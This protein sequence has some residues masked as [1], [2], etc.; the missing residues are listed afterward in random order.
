[1]A[2]ANLGYFPKSYKALPDPVPTHE[3]QP[4]LYTHQ[5]YQI[6]QP[7]LR[8]MATLLSLEEECWSEGMRAS[9]DVIRQRI[10]ENTAGQCLL[11]MDGRAIGVIY[12]QRVN[13]EDKIKAANDGNVHLLHER[14]GVLAQ[15]LAVNVFPNMQHLGLGDQLLAFMVNYSFRRQGIEKVVAVTRCKNYVMHRDMTME[16]YIRARNKQGLL[17][18][19]ILRFHDEHGASIDALIPNYRAGDG[20]NDG[21]GV[22]ISYDPAKGTTE[23]KEVAKAD[24]LPSHKEVIK[25]L[26]TSVKDL[27]EGQPRGGFQSGRALLDMGLDSLDL[28][29]LRLQLVNQL[30]VD[31]D[32]T[33]FFK[34]ATPEA[35]A[36]YISTPKREVNFKAQSPQTKTQISAEPAKPGDI[37]RIRQQHLRAISGEAV[38]V[39]GMACRLGGKTNNVDDFWN[40][41]EQGVD[42]IVEVPRNRYDI[43]RYYNPEPGHPGSLISK[44]GS[45]IENVD[46][47]D[48]EFF[49]INPREA[50]HLDPSQ[51]TLMEVAW[52]ALEDACLDPE[53]LKGT[54]AGI[55]TGVFSTDYE[56]LQLREQ[57]NHVWDAYFATGNCSSMTAGRL[58]YFLGFQ[59]PAI[60]VNTAC[61]S[62]LVAVHLACRS[63]MSGE[64][65][66]AL[67]GGV[68][69][70]LSP[71][72]SIAFSRAGMLSPDGR[73]KTFD[74]TANGYVRGEGC[75]IVVLKSLNKAIAAN[76]RIQGILRGGAINQDGASNGLTAPNGQAQE[77]VIRE[78]L[79]TAGV[80]PIDINYVEA[81]GTGTPLGDPIEVNALRDIY[82]PGRDWDNPLYVGSVKTNIGHTEAAA[83]VVGLIK[84]VLSMKNRKI[85]QHLHFKEPNP[86]LSLEQ[87]PA[88]IPTETVDWP[89]LEKKPRLGS[90][91]SFGFSG[92]NAHMVVQ[93]GLPPKPAKYSTL[94]HQMLALS[95][96]SPKALTELTKNFATFLEQDVDLTSACLSA[97]VGRSHFFHRLAVT[98]DSREEMR[99]RLLEEAE[100]E[101]PQDPDKT[102]ALAFL[103]TGQGSQY[104]NMGRELYENLPTFRRAIDQCDEILRDVADIHLIESLYP[105]FEDPHALNQTEIT[106]PAIFS[107][108]YA[109]YQVW[110][111]WGIE[112]Q[113][114]LGHS[115]GEYVAAHVAGIYSL[116]DGLRLIAE[117][118]RLMQRLPFGGAMAAVMVDEGTLLEVLAGFDDISIAAFNGPRS[119]VISGRED[120]IDH[121]LQGF[122]ERG[123]KCKKLSVSHAFHSALMNPMLDQ[124]EAEAARL[125]LKPPNIDFI[126]SVT[127]AEASAA[128][129]TPNY[130]R[131]Q[132]RQAVLFRP[133]VLT[134]GR[135][136][137]NTFLEIGPT[138]TL[139]ALGRQ[140]MPDEATFLSSLR[141]GRS[142]WT[143]MLDTLS[144]LYQR[145]ASV[146]FSGLHK[147]D[148]VPKI[149][150]PGYP[151]QRRSFWFERTRI[152]P[153]REVKKE[154]R[155]THPLLGRRL[156]MAVRQREVVFDSRL[157][158]KSAAYLEDYRVGDNVLLPATASLEMAR[159]AGAVVFE[160]LP[161]IVEDVVFQKDLP[162][163]EHDEV[164]VQFI[165][166]P[167]TAT[168]S[169]F[170]IYSLQDDQH[171]LH[172]DFEIHVKG[173]LAA[174][175]G[176]PPPDRVDVDALRAS[177][178]EEM[179]GTLLYPKLQRVGLEYGT[180]MQTIK[181]IWYSSNHALGR[182]TI[183]DHLHWDEEHYA[184]HP[185]LLKGAFQLVKLLATT[186]DDTAM[187]PRSLKR[188]TIFDHGHGSL[189]CHAHVHDNMADID[190]FTDDG[191]VI[192]KIEGLGLEEVRVLPQPEAPWHKWLMQHC[193]ES[194]SLQVTLPQNKENQWLIFATGNRTAQALIDQMTRR[195]QQCILVE[196]GEDF[197]RLSDRHFALPSRDEHAYGQLLQSLTEDGEAIDGVVY[198]GSEYEKHQAASD[199]T[200]GLLLLVRA[201]ME[202]G[203]AK[204]PHLHVVTR[205]A[206]LVQDGETLPGHF[207]S[208]LRGFTHVVSLEH[209]ELL[210]QA[211]DLDPNLDLHELE[212]ISEA[213]IASLGE[214]EEYQK[215]ERFVAWR[216]GKAFVK[217]L[218]PYTMPEVETYS[219][220]PNASYM[221]TGGLG[222]LGLSLAQ[223]L[224]DRG[225]R[226]LIL[227]SRRGKRPELEDALRQLTATGAR[228]ITPHLDVTE[229]E[230]VSSLIGRL[231]EEETP[232]K[233]IIHAAGILDDGIIACLTP[234]R[235]ERVM[236]PKVIGAWNLHETTRTLDLDFFVNFSSIASLL[237][238]A[239]QSNYTAGNRYLD[240]LAHYRRSQGLKTL[241][242]NWC[243]FKGGGMAAEGQLWTLRELQDIDTSHA[244]DFL[245][246][247][248]QTDEA[249]IGIAPILPE[250]YEQAWTQHPMFDLIRP[251]KAAT[252]K[253]Q[254]DLRKQLEDA[255]ESER[256]RLLGDWL[257][258][259]IGQILGISSAE[260]I[261]RS[262]GF[263]TLG[264]DSLAAIEFRNRLQA[265]LHTSLPSTLTFDYPTLESLGN[266]ILEHLFGV[267]EQQEPISEPAAPQEETL[268]NE[269]LS[270]EE[271]HS[272]IDAEL[273]ELQKLGLDI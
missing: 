83:G 178:A 246:Q 212:N 113:A 141:R 149:G 2:A 252:A 222:S 123:V 163:P 48:N 10:E 105:E 69:L 223:S 98:A 16:D 97:N 120:A 262:R 54:K 174:P 117:R 8:D 261:S 247:A 94:T 23:H 182:L 76:D 255:T 36:Q 135:L 3:A 131:R 84:M 49:H 219:P 227:T 146:N 159:A 50:A 116:E 63:I 181:H 265:N 194:H 186:K 218:R 202:E 244:W 43:E 197:K 67:A 160:R 142:D 46:G 14:D 235:L 196:E 24:K 128:N 140:N 7:G 20:D 125:R 151:F 61:S 256:I 167:E 17:L 21:I 155:G 30:N 180:S 51:R 42:G 161:I 143:T 107:L 209:P 268:L 85:P 245:F 201:L 168:R 41:L 119:Q 127:G 38:A 170:G 144:A 232:L 62:S 233:G 266:F 253:P 19:P 179:P 156:R 226:H 79:S 56:R 109:L 184:I 90:I 28:Y 29:G 211:H 177:M 92:T 257:R 176:H 91:S 188:M 207:Q 45:F 115:V 190:I 124:F 213:L 77:A 187:L 126:S 58:S 4:D 267:E 55:F 32:P 165:L 204:L 259:H 147:H 57:Q 224:V 13:S 150:V 254:A 169:Q 164:Q 215:R 199:S 37:A 195:G 231:K 153:P 221:I 95:A 82:G 193:W 271:V 191:M 25:L 136:G 44:Y 154:L 99:Q 260:P 60:A 53:K 59:G 138:P 214:Q 106:Q 12:S 101:H 118:G 133:G 96:R 31:L 251:K 87:I 134:L 47:F 137:Y 122:A 6:R 270:A 162:L 18:D 74:S 33:F 264:M 263:S 40:M 65:T 68:N 148:L 80:S 240:A 183:P 66:V 145:G 216:A 93:E 210:C 173:A 111:S 234:H 132:V 228:V 157:F 203:F 1:M 175:E 88:V 258:G 15:L 26:E 250:A 11:E 239:G 5:N 171:D 102:Q 22:L 64:C 200:V 206:C 75:G 100:L 166:E 238:S 237:G 71:D 108:E 152:K 242:V 121:A 243:A 249:C 52:Q 89:A 112:P 34:Y 78:A 241:S 248:V 130:W 86:L 9:R 208:P 192:A 27:L 81:H 129:I 273:E 110:S 39:V 220:D 229:Y 217:R 272:L 104:P 189:F 230:Q 198:F 205:G 72:L 114:V 35:I 70:I 236:A 172:P 225:A 158:R 269:D 73:C 139:S 185:A 103:F